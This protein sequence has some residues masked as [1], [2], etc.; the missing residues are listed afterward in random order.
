MYDAVFGSECGLANIIV[1][2]LDIVT[3]DLGFDD[4]IHYSMA[5]LVVESRAYA[6]AIAAAEIPRSACVGIAVYEDMASGRTNWVGILVKW[7]IEFSQSDM[8]R[9]RVDFWSRLRVNL[10]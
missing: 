7:A 8:A 5:S 6:V 9:D 10:A 4:C 1:Q 3:D 2:V